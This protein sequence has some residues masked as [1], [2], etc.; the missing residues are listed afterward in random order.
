MA[1]PWGVRLDLPRIKHL[2]VAATR[3][4]LNAGYGAIREEFIEFSGPFD[5]GNEG[6]WNITVVNVTGGSLCHY[7]VTAYL[8][9]NASQ[10]L[11]KNSTVTYLERDSFAQVNTTLTVPAVDVLNGEYG[12]YL[13][14][15]KSQGWVTRLPLSFNVS[16]GIE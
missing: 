6:L 16:A 13:E 1:H 3:S 8:W 5:K 12:G 14:Y 15:Y 11:G 10:W 9:F 2:H 7:N 4:S